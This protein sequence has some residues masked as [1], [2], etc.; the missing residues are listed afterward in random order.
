MPNPFSP[1]RAALMALAAIGSALF[2]LV[3]RRPRRLADRADGADD[4]ASFAAGIAD[5]GLIP[6]VDPVR[7][8]PDVETVAA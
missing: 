6:D 7:Q 4:S 8:R 5:E 2:L 3:R 1:S